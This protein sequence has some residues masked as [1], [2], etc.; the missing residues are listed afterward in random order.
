[1]TTMRQSAGM[2]F[3]LAGAFVALGCGGGADRPPLGYVTGTVTLNGEPLVGVI[4]LFK[5]DN[6]RAATSITDSRGVYN[7]EYVYGVKGT[8]VG[9]S[10]VS[11]EWPLDYP[12]AKPL[13]EKYTMKSALKEE[14]KS[15]RNT[16][17]FD[18]KSDETS[19]PKPVKTAD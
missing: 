11:F 5:P 4:V 7:L 6:G 1:M 14:V 19:T 17:N 13:P 18:L 12:G 10:T 8:K 2:W 15:G 3:L 16:F 9:P